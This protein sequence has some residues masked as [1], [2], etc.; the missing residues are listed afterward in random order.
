MEE[1]FKKL[2]E[3]KTIPEQR[4]IA[5][6]LNIEFRVPSISAQILEHGMVERRKRCNSKDAAELV[7]IPE[8]H[9]TDGKSIP[10]VLVD[11]RVARSIGIEL[12][13]ISDREGY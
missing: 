13:R 4:K 10:G 7:V 2:F 6:A 9:L 12:L 1:M 8:V 3:G 11:P 5:K